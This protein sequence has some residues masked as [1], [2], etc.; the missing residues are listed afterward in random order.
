M[1]TEQPAEDA[2]DAEANDTPESRSTG[3]R[4][5]TKLRGSSGGGGGVSEMEL[6]TMSVS[7]SIATEAKTIKEMH[8]SPMK[9]KNKSSKA[10]SDARATL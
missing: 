3:R 2:E 7:L 5:R 9:K 6:S 4:K 1:G 10:G 8:G